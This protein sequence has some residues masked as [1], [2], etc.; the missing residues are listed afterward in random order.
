MYG[1]YRPEVENVGPILANMNRLPYNGNPQFYHPPQPTQ[2][3]P[4]PPTHSPSH[5]SPSEESPKQE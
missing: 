2:S 3:S 5:P 4:Q 1:T